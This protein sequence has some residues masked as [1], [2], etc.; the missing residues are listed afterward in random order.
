MVDDVVISIFSSSKQNKDTRLLLLRNILTLSSRSGFVR[1]I[2]ILGLEMF[3][4]VWARVDK[5]LV[6]QVFTLHM[7]PQPSPVL[8]CPQA[9]PTLPQVPRLKHLLLYQPLYL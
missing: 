5:T 1:L 2:G 3:G 8:G 7:L 4:T 9:D 6:T